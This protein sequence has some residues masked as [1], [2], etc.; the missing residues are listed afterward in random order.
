MEAMGDS[1]R[2]ALDGQDQPDA[3]LQPGAEDRMLTVRLRL[4]PGDDLILDRHRA[5]PQSLQLR[6]NEPNPVAGLGA[7]G[8]LRADLIIDPVLGIDE[9]LKVKSSH[10]QW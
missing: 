7:S 4:L 1:G 2:L 10:A 3:F 8:Q 9:A 5:A 6:E